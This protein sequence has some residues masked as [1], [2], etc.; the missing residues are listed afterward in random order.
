MRLQL[1]FGNLVLAGAAVVSLVGSGCTKTDT[2]A[3]DVKNVAKG[4]A[5][6]DGDHSGWWCQEHGIPEHLCSMCS[7]EVAAKHKKEGDWCKE[8]DRAKSQCFKCDPTL[9]EK[10]EAMYVA[11]YGKTPEPPP[12]TEFEK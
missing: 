4:D 2:P 5:K 12:T 3:K 1:W 6:K 10:Y 11:K 7:E 9:Y 8:H